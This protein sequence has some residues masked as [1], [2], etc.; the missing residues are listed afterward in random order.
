[1]KKLFP[2]FI[3][4]TT[5]MAIAQTLDITSKKQLQ[6]MEEQLKVHTDS[7]INS[8][9]FLTR[10]KSDSAF[11]RGFVQALKT[12]NSFYYNFDSLQ[13]SKLMSPDSSFKIFTW[14]V[15]K[16]FSYYR[17]R[18]AIQMKT[19]DGSLKLFPLFDV[20][21]FTENPL[22]SVR[23]ANRWI[24]A[25][26]YNIVMKKVSKTTYY[27][28]L[29]SDGN[30]ARSN[31]KYIEI[32]TFNA[33]GKPQF[34]APIFSYPNDG[35]KPYPPAYRF[36]LEFKKDGGA[37][38]NYEKNSG[39]IFM[40]HLISESNEPSLKYTLVP[41]G[42]YEGFKW[43]KGKWVFTDVPFEKIITEK[44]NYLPKPDKDLKEN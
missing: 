24:G 14:Q 28:L 34:G 43:V 31:K 37:R 13:I 10:F 4:L 44:P 33:E 29:G 26:Y 16:D 25:I 5:N 6:Q 40:D 27:T 36:C 2:I 12:K 18:G 23:D 1:M 7:I 32:L 8:E 35:I 21:D 39:I 22:D 41:Y 3:L 20:S 11:V 30:D 19:A 38:M 9:D 17:Q 15:M 42:D